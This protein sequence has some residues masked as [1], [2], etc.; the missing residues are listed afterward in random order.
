MHHLMHHAHWKS[1]MLA[2]YSE[3]TMVRCKFQRIDRLWQAFNSPVRVDAILYA[4]MDMLR[5]ILSNPEDTGAGLFPPGH[6]DSKLPCRS[7]YFEDLFIFS[8][9]VLHRT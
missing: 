5:K 8:N 7:A 1:C 2:C 6:P 9:D 3:V 4:T